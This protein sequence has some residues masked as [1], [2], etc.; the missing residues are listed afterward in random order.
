VYPTR[1]GRLYPALAVVALLLLL[2]AQ[3][4]QI[5]AVPWSGR[6]WTALPDAVHGSWFACVTTIV[7][8]FVERMRTGRS[9]FVA[10]ALIGMCLAVGT[11][12]VQGMTGGDAEA[13]DV[14]FDM[15]GMSAALCFW[16]V[17]RRMSRPRLGYGGA[18][19]LLVA[20]LW[21]LVPAIAVDRCRDSIAPEL[22]RFDSPCLHE[23]YSVNGP[24]EIVPAPQPWSITG[25]V[26][27]VTL[28]GGT[29]VHFDD[30]IA[31]WRPYSELEVDVFVAGDAL[32]PVSVSV[33]LDNAPVDHVYRTFDCAPGQCKIE[34]PLN[35]LFDRDVARVN[36]VVVYTS[37]AAT[38]RVMYIGRV[39][40][41]R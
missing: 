5:V 36:A 10:T 30:P 17:R 24:T 35:G 26:L 18:A 38:G 14:F 32:L 20:S 40:L 6:V 41:R 7:L 21:P 3:Q 23:L 1:R 31:D 15:V 4:Q 13:G 39:V 34:L 29:A 12:V 28:G 2:F 8:F 19:T 37:R 25:P 9:A 22:I 11:E 16:S 27:K 33:R